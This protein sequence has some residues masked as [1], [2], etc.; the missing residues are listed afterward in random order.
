M[1][2]SS[3][4]TTLAA[5]SAPP[6]SPFTVSQWQ[7]LEHQALI[8]KYLIAGLPVPPDLV[9]PIQNSFRMSSPFFHHSSRKYPLFLLIGLGLSSNL[10]DHEGGI[11]MG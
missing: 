8:Y 6:T 11:L 7:E 5:A 4:S 3:G 9:L 1:T 10:V 2:S